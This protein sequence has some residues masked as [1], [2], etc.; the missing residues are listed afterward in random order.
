MRNA[1]GH[2]FFNGNYRIDY[3]RTFN[4]AGTKFHYER[5]EHR[6]Q[7]PQ[8]ITA[9]GPTTEGVYLVVSSPRK[10]QKGPNLKTKYLNLPP[11]VLDPVPRPGPAG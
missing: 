8:S 6:I 2:Y 4:I 7:A 11:N 1:S 10:P 9:K 5:P 3:P